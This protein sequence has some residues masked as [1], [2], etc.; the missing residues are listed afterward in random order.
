MSGV[1]DQDYEH[2]R[3]VWSKFG[4]NN[5]GEYRDL[6]LCT[7]IILLANVLEAFRKIC[8]DN[9]GLDP[10]HFYMVLRLT[11]HACLKK[12]RIRLE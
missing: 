3:R 10:A 12:T 6:Y 4:I 2:A 11:W 7:D 5:L 1:S 8:L 9:C